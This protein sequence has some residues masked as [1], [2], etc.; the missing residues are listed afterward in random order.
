MNN[1]KDKILIIDDTLLNITILNDILCPDY[2]VLYSQSGKRG[3]EIALSEKPS[4]ILL[5]II[6]P[7]I[8]GY[9]ICRKIKKNPVTSEIPVIFVTSLD[10]ESDEERGLEAGAIDY[11]SK[12]FSSMVVKLRIKNHIELKK[13]RDM[14]EKLS[15]LDGLTGIP[16]RRQ[17]NLFL[18]H[19]W[20]SA[21][22]TRLPIS[23]VMADIDYFKSFNDN[24][25]HL[26]GDECLKKVAKALF[27]V[28]K[29]GTDLVARY[30][31]E[32]FAI[33][34]PGTDINGALLLAE[35][36]RESVEKLKIVHEYSKSS[37][38]I[39][40]SVGVSSIV[41]SPRDLPEMLINM[42]DK[43]LYTAKENG[44]NQVKC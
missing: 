30:G 23:I 36:L 12:P 16:N 1:V 27:R 44:R 15:T 42:S 34:L 32:E 40:V 2:E 22:R 19:E 29:R 17:F 11:V 28:M 7:E 43:M 18:E 3:L 31:G 39:T 4:L 41:P 10:E 8:D 37:N 9:E 5:D 33:V 21:I 25:G 38:H 6:M 20:R 14:L 26:A 24:Y 35:E 13:H